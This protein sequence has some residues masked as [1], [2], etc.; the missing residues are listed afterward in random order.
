[1]LDALIDEQ[2][3]GVELKEG[4]EI[5]VNG[6]KV[7]FLTLN[8]KKLF[9]G[10]ES[11]DARKPAYYMVKDIKVFNKKR[12]LAEQISK[13]EGRDYVMDLTL[14][15][16]YLQNALATVEAGGETKTVG[17]HIFGLLMGEKH[18]A[19]LYPNPN[20][21]NEDGIPRKN[22]N[23]LPSRFSQGVNRIVR[24]E[25]CPRS[26]NKEKTIDNDFQTTVK[27]NEEKIESE[28]LGEVFAKDGNISKQ[29]FN[30]EKNKYFK[31]A[32]GR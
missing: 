24:Y 21:L 16:E 25:L 2:L 26:G 3:P 17:S 14:K 4:G 13:G 1:M 8:G 28:S 27:W 11:G 30:K 22:G 7:D 6:K 29:G 18:D 32:T 5:F 12:T 10:N 19:M 23:W 31:L 9:K 15:R 20:N